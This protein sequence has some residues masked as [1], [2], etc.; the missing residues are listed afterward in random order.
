MKAMT[1]IKCLGHFALSFTYCL[2]FL[3]YHVEW[4][5]LVPGVAYILFLI[6]DIYHD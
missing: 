3:G 5:Y 6:L 1:T 2:F 4:L